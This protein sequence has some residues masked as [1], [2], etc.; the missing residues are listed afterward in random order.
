M[1]PKIIKTA[2]EHRLYLA[3]VERL[4]AL[5][6]ATNSSESVRLKLLATIVEDYEKKHFPFRKPD[7]AELMAFRK[8]QQ[9]LR[10]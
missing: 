8:E 4:I 5:H 3:E 10:Q 9:G 6:P 1:A 7:A 2:S